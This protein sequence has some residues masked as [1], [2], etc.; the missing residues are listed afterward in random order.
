M[1]AFDQGGSCA[2]SGTGTA[3]HYTTHQFTLASSTNVTISLL[4][5]DGA[6]VTPSGADTFIILYGPGG[7]NPADACANAIIAN[8]DADATT[9]LSKIVTSAPLAAGNYTLVITTFDNIPSPAL[10]YTYTGFSSVSFGA[11]V[12]QHVV[13]YNGD[14]KSDYIVARATSSPL[15]EAKGPSMLSSMGINTE[16][17][18]HTSQ[19]IRGI[20]GKNDLLSPPIFW[21]VALNGSNATGVAQ[22][23]D[24]ASPDFVVSG[25]F[26]GDSKTDIAVWTEAPATQANFKILQSSNNTVRVEFFGQTD[27]D[28]SVVGD[29][30]GDGKADPAV[31]RC[32]VSP[33]PAGQCYFFFRG[34]LNN[35]SGNVTYVPWGFGTDLDFFSYVGDFDGDHKN[36]FC[37]QR[38]NPSSPNNGQFVLLKSNG[39]GVEF[40]NWGLATDF[41]VSGDYDGDG[42]TDF[43]V[44]RSDDPSIDK[45]TYYVLT[46]TGATF[47]AQW[48]VVGDSSTPGDYDG[49]GKTDFAV[50]RGSATAGDSRFWILNSSNGSVSQ[51]IWGQS[52]DFA[53][54]G[55]AV[56]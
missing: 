9:L 27:D 5:A 7:F 15:A 10:P 23:G 22:L 13:D 47:G 12:V 46:R 52:G 16:V 18:R 29:Y 39:G 26:D 14:G 53:V 35:P 8:D 56:H 21:Y 38:S 25:D 20:T 55:W 45:R 54:A 6:T 4:P 48:G 51:F 11:A 19:I 28:P 43:C 40:I 31:F 44:R 34:S 1:I 33:A 41:L 50:W 30:D 49:D 32:P 42:K 17:R 37:L 24:A 36:D 2:L 3:V